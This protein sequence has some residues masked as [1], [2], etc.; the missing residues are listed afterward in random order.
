ME[1]AGYYNNYNEQSKD[2][3]NIDS[4][5]DKT[6]SVNT[7]KETPQKETPNKKTTDLSPRQ[8]KKETPNKKTDKLSLR[9]KSVALTAAPKNVS[10]VPNATHKNQDNY[11]E[12]IPGLW[13][14]K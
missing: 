1:K 4:F 7:S 2:T 6:Q 13:K 5:L 8:E 14:K 9:A 12:N 10:S 11:Y 3:I